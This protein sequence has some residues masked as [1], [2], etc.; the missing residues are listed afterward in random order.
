LTPFETA[1]GAVVWLCGNER[2][3]AGL[4]PLGF[5]GAARQA[6][7]ALTTIEPR[8]LPADCR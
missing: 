7:R 2:P 8:Y 4:E 6:A 1:A 3:G 5:A